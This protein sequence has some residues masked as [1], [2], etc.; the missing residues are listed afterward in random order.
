MRCLGC[1]SRATSERSD[2]TELGYRRFRCR[3]C[4]RGFKNAVSAQRFCR[5]YDE[6][7]HALRFPSPRGRRLSLGERRWFHLHR[8]N[9]LLGTMEQT[10][11]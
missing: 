11:T 1:T 5:A 2:R 8:V 7:R 3:D 6:V 10:A 9:R 4:D